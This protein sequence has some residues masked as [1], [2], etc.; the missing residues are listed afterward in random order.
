MRWADMTWPDLEKV[1]PGTAILWPVASCEQHGYHLPVFTDSYIVSA[2]GDEIEQKLPD[3]VLLLPTLWLGASHHHRFFPGALSLPETLYMQVLQRVLECLID[4]PVCAPGKVKRIFLLNAH[5]GNM[6]PGQAVLSEVAW[7]FRHRPEVIVA[8]GSYWVTSDE[9]MRSAQLET[10]VLTHACEYETSLVLAIRGELVH[11]DRAVAYD[12]NWKNTRFTP[13]ASRPSKVVVAAP[14]HARS[15]NGA[16]GSPELASQEKG[17]RL[18]RAVSDDLVQFM[19][20]F[21]AW[22]D[23]DRARPRKKAGVRTPRQPRSRARSRAR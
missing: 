7:K 23:L 5:G 8:F 11:M 22:P 12:V 4:S 18:L 15:A 10:S 19:D 21:L 6:Y 3:R 20:E 9:A 17:E 13:D 14:F 1:G 16:L 2:L